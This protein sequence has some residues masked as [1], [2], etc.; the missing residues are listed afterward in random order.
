M[1]MMEGFCLGPLFDFRPRS[2]LETL[3]GLQDKTDKYI[4]A[5]ELAKAKR[6]KRGNEDQKRK[7]SDTRQT[8]YRGELKIKRS[9]RDARR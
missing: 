5:E 7:E 4:T 2:I 9:E 6:R 3:S 8:D 1:V